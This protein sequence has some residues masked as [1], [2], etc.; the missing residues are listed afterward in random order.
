MSAPIP[1]TCLDC[2]HLDLVT[3]TPAYSEWTPG[4]PGEWV[5]RKG[6]Y[7]LG[8]AEAFDKRTLREKIVM[9]ATCTE[10]QP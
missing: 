7:R 2:R 1:P 4:D 6:M 9:A 5:C 3:P 8:E 10:F